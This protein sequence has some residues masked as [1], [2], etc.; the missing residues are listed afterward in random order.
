ML[1]TLISSIKSINN[2]SSS[3]SL[4]INYKLKLK[5]TLQSNLF[6]MF[7]ASK[8]IKKTKK[9][10]QLLKKVSDKTFLDSSKDKIKNKV[11]NSIPVMVSNYW[12]TASKIIKC[13]LYIMIKN[14]RK[15]RKKTLLKNKKNNK[16]SKMLIKKIINNRFKK[17]SLH[18]F[19][20]KMMRQLHK[21]KL[22]STSLN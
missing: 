13:L 7:S 17:N 21:I 15:K 19:N 14:K 9:W 11:D 10:M 3:L 8:N 1:I 18:K 20:R 6:T 4:S 5:S 22:L 16:Q 12:N 2:I